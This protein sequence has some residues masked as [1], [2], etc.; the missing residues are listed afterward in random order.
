ML[1]LLLLLT[2]CVGTRFAPGLT[3]EGR[4]ELTRDWLAQFNQLK[5]SRVPLVI[6]VKPIDADGYDSASAPVVKHARNADAA[7]EKGGGVNSP[8][9]AGGGAGGL[10][11]PKNPAMVEPAEPAFDFLTSR[12]YVTEFIVATLPPRDANAP[13]ET[14]EAAIARVKFDRQLVFSSSDHLVDVQVRLKFD[15]HHHPASLQD[16]FGMDEESQDCTICWSDP[17]E[18]I[19]LPCR[20][21]NVCQN[22]MQNLSKCPVCRAP[23]SNFLRFTAS[24]AAAATPPRSPPPQVAVVAVP[25][26]AVSPAAH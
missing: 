24:A 17:K 23:I 15:F 25:V 19:L 20:H 16:V 14:P 26:S 2:H 12:H 10:S 13:M 6:H 5:D 11:S 22:C 7:D 3:Q 21:V 9:G 8:A 4:I 1:L 18:V